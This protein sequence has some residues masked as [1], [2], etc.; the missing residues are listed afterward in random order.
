MIVQDKNLLELI[1]VIRNLKSDSE[2]QEF[3][4]GILTPKELLEIPLRLQIVKQLKQGKSQR[5]IAESLGVGIATVTRGSKELLL[6]R[7]QNV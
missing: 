6:G 3:F 5:E 2:L 4:K 7:F 1:K